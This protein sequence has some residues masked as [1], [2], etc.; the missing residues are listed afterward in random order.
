MPK[1][2]EKSSNQKEEN[3]ELEVKDFIKTQEI[4]QFVSVNAQK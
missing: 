3:E 1:S 2:Q 4:S